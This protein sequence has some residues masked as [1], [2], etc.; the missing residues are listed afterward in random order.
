H[1]INGTVGMRPQTKKQDVNASKLGVHKSLGIR[2]WTTAHSG[3]PEH[4]NS[5]PVL[6]L[7]PNRSFQILQEFNKE[8]QFVEELIYKRLAFLVTIF[9]FAVAGALTARDFLYAGALIFLIG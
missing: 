7:E 8:R 9:G 6:K 4:Q 3:N 1:S 2:S 5:I